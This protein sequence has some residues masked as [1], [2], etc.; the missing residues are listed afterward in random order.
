MGIANVDK[1]Q[2]KVHQL[3]TDHG[4]SIDV[5]KYTSMT[6][7]QYKQGVK[8]FAT[9]VEVTGRGTRDP[10]ADDLALIGS[11]EPVEIMFVISRLELIDKFPALPQGEWVTNDDE[12]GFEGHR[13][14]I[15]RIWEAG[16]IKDSPTIMV[17]T[18]MTPPGE[19]R[20]P[21]P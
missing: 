9:A 4:S 16:R 11:N 3:L 2:A 21:Y 13:Y 15:V 5:L 6:L 1:I 12:I 17:I 20:T 19:E 8:T 14:R 18:G 10:T 7:D